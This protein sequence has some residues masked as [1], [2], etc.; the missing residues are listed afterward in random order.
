MLRMTQRTLQVSCITCEA[1]A[2]TEKKR[3]RSFFSGRLGRRHAFFFMSIQESTLITL[4]QSHLARLREEEKKQQINLKREEII[5][6]V[7]SEPVNKIIEG[8]VTAREALITTLTANN[9]EVWNRIK[10]LG[11]S[12]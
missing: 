6:F 5:Q 10:K 2:F 3:C 12:T 4:L 1:K 9:F 7:W 8:S 11:S